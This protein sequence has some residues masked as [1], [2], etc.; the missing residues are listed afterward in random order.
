MADVWSRVLV[1][2]DEEI[3]SLDIPR[4]HVRPPTS[5][6]LRLNPIVTGYSPKGVGRAECISKQ[7]QALVQSTLPTSCRRVRHTLH[8]LCYQLRRRLDLW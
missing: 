1:S 3:I 5:L 8:P 7:H 6:T 4:T 2:L